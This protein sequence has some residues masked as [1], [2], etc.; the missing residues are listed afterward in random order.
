M[1]AR[2]QP[3]L[4]LRP[5]ALDWTLALHRFAKDI[6]DDFFPDALGYADLLDDRARTIE[7]IE[8]ISAAY[9]PNETAR[10]HI[11]K[12]NFTLRDCINLHPIDRV[13]YQALIDKLITLIDPKLTQAAFSHRLRAPT[14]KWMFRN[15][16]EQ[17]RAFEVALREGLTAARESWVVVTDLSQY[18]ENINFHKL[19]RHLE[20][21]LGDDGDS[22]HRA[23][24]DTLSACLQMWSPYTHDGLPQNI[25]ASSFLGNLFL[26]LVDKV[27]LRSGYQYFRYM[28]DMRI[29][30][31][32]EAEAR[33]A[34][35]KLISTLREIGLGV[36]AGKTR[37]L[38]PDS[39]EVAAIL[40]GDDPDVELIEESTRSKDPA[41]IEAIVPLLFE[42]AKSL[43]AAG[44]TGER[45]F[46]FCVNRIT[47]LRR[48]RDLTLP[49]EAGL[50]EALIELLRHRPVDT[51][52]LVRYLSS[53]QINVP[54][55]QQIEELLIAEPLCVY[56]WQ[57]YHLWILAVQQGINSERLL[58]FA[59]RV[60]RNRPS[61]PEVDGAVLFIGRFGNYADR[62]ALRSALWD[63]Q[64]I[65]RRRSQYIA[66][67]EL[68][69]GERVPFYR[70][71]A[72]GDRSL[73]MLA[74]YLNQRPAPS[75]VPEPPPIQIEDLYD[76]VPDKVS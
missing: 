42:K 19:I 60:L 68:H 44:S 14:D 7:A 62:E 30:V 57:N 36:N 59:H 47:A 22:S 48:Y 26:D 54:H 2:L 8:E 43:L 53:A 65:T 58:T 17:W 51:D 52:T 13:V 12:A 3:S 37:I 1:N 66:V 35:I 71:N 29:V 39:D 31:S 67:Q 63:D 18:Y 4:N 64:R 69:P 25:D 73:R 38:G 33:K 32:S 61:G 72:F 15:S 74:T 45:E 9:T 55:K 34:L 50:T 75:Y 10:L 21:L 40:K 20:M 23:C 28:D 41:K 56:P 16:I 5:L 49:E 27:M 46:R 70:Q 76:H 24:I 6:R 11:P